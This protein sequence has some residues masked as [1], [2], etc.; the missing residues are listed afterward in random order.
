MNGDD[1]KLVVAGAV[2]G[3]VGTIVYIAVVGWSL[4]TPEPATTAEFLRQ[5]GAQPHG[6]WMHFLVSG[7]A[8]LWAVGF[9][10][11]GKLMASGPSPKLAQVGTVFGVVASGLFVTM[12]IVQGAVMVNLGHTFVI[13]Q[14]DA[15]RESAIAL[16]RGLRVIDQG[17]DLA[18]D[19][20]FFTAWICMGISMFRH[21]RFGKVLGLC[22]ILLFAL[23]APQQIWY[24]P[25]PPPI[26]IGPIG[27]LLIV[28][29]FVQTFRV[30]RQ[31]SQAAAPPQAG[32]SAGGD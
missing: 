7:A 3:A 9:L 2:C 6:M 18:F 17:I 16:Y 15:Q 5:A 22:V 10:G 1:C 8:L 24:A 29:V 25:N 11:L 14:S 31:L 20:F 19:S 4:L 27:A 13:A 26:E 32:A 30:G 21:P 23:D 28:A 12:L